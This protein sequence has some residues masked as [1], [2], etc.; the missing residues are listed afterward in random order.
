MS[1]PDDE[2]AEDPG[3]RAQ[4]VAFR[5]LGLAE[6]PAE[7]RSLELWLQHAAGT[8]IFEKIRAPGLATISESASPEVREAVK[9]AVDATIYAL[10]MQIDGVSEP[11]IGEEHEVQLNFG[12]SLWRGETMVESLDLSEGDGMCIGYHG[13]LE[14]DFGEDPVLA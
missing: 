6:P 12:V 10:M 11:L 3:M 1:S 7:R 8:L 5:Q 2:P 4:D 14:G 9:A 13:W